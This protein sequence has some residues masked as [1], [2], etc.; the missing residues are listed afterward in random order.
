MQNLH[1]PVLLDS[2]SEIID[3]IQP[4][5]PLTIFDATFGG[6]G[7][8]QKF[9]E[10][11]NIVFACD[12]DDL[13]VDFLDKMVNSDIENQ[14]ENTEISV[15]KNHF[16]KWNKFGNLHFKQGNFA[17]RIQDFDDNFFDIIIADLGFSS[18]QLEFATRGFSH[19]KPDEILD[20][21]FH[22]SISQPCY[23][24][25]QKLKKPEELSKIIYKYSGEISSRSIGEKIYTVCH[26]KNA[27][28]LV[29]DILME[30]KNYRRETLSRVWQALRIWTNQEFE[31]LETLINCGVKK[32]KPNGLLMIVSFHSLEDKIVTKFMRQISKP[33][34]IDNFGNNTQ[35]FEIL[36][37][38]AILPS[39]KEINDNPRSRSSKLRILKKLEI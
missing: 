7:Y 24:K 32:L 35:T 15:S 13:A 28:I 18:N 33:I 34:M 23:K 14:T 4:K 21:R 39:E 38:K 11:E 5:K 37:K 27:Q 2:I 12:L 16:I 26:Q 8:T 17:E 6:G 22:P 9:L 20:L 3:N 36:T 1:I 29:A 30:L 19:Q 31:N 10:M 25:I